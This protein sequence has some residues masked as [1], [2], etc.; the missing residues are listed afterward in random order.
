MM[1][2]M[3]PP[4]MQPGVMPAA[5]QTPL[6][7]VPQPATA[8][9]TQAAAPAPIAAPQP[10]AAAPQPSPPSQQQ[11]SAATTAGDGGQKTVLLPLERR[12]APGAKP[13]ADHAE[14]EFM[15]EL[16]DIA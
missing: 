9:P 11:P 6:A 12:A 10:P 1:P 3:V 15:T 16:P 2:G 4:V 7:A 14:L 13:A 8:P 5:P